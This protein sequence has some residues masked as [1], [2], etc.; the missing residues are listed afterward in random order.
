MIKAAA[1]AILMAFGP[2]AGAWAQGAAC[3]A[4]DE[5]ACMLEAAW[6]AA[7]AL[8]EQKQ[9][10]LKPLFGPLALQLTDPKVRAVWNARLGE[11]G[12]DAAGTDYVRQ[13]AETAIRE[14]GWEMF[15]QRARDGL[16]PLHTGRPEI[17]GAAIEL[18]PDTKQRAR[19]IE[20]MFSL[21]GTADIRKI[22]GIS[23]NA[24]ERADFGHVLA[25]R[26]MRDCRLAEFDRAVALTAAPASLRYA[27]WRARIRGGA[28]ALAPDIRAGD[29]SD[30]TSH[31][32]QALEGYGA[33]LSLGYCPK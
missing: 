6:T 23:V 3:P 4:K 12:I 17:M 11:T 8:P 28:G 18:A 26:M 32:R 13:T 10:R 30:D 15:L 22:S 27:L 14:Y 33:I 16:A 7:E 5:A 29:G 20:M 1:F 19:L 31:V 9:A 21:A 2:L 24:F 25:E